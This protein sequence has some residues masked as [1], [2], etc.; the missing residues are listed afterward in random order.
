M[1]VDLQG[2]YGGRKVLS[3]ALRNRFLEL[4]RQCVVVVFSFSSSKRLCH[5][6]FICVRSTLPIFRTT[7]CKQLSN[8][9][10]KY[11]RKKRHEYD[12]LGLS[13]TVNVVANVVCE[14]HGWRHGWFASTSNCKSSTH[15]VCRLFQ[16]N[17]LLQASGAF[18]GKHG[19]VTFR[20]LFRW[21]QVNRCRLKTVKIMF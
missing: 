15:S 16:I 14:T 10:V 17:F 3:R 8:N 5:V 6:M 1:I 9:V 4:V 2:A 11:V 12:W 19:A 13:P 20:D 7:N 18:G 21:A